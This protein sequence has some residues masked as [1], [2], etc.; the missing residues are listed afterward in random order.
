MN[1]VHVKRGVMVG[2]FSLSLLLGGG[3]TLAFT[4]GGG[5]SGN[6]PGQANAIANC[7]DTITTQNANGQTGA[8]TGSAN[9]P[10]QLDTGVTNCDH[11]WQ[12]IGAIGN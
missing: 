1:M 12:T 11:F 5:N 10:K 9:D 6:A 8:Q 3:A 7:S 2:A 4:N